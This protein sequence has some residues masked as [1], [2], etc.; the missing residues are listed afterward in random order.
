MLNDAP[1]L[2]LKKIGKSLEI[3]Y[4]KDAQR[5]NIYD[6]Q[7]NFYSPSDIY[8]ALITKDE[9][10]SAT[11]TSTKTTSTGKARNDSA[12]CRDSDNIQMLCLLKELSGL[13]SE[14]DTTGYSKR[15]KFVMMACIRSDVVKKQ[16]TSEDANINKFVE[17]NKK[18][19]D[20]AMDIASTTSG[21]ST[22]SVGAAEDEKIKIEWPTLNGGRFKRSLMERIGDV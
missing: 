8:K 11:M 7:K 3:E 20:F 19:L 14:D 17:F 15:T 9:G 18:T 22:I 10:M 21:A 12:K 2:G 5:R 1:Q 16:G 6:A 4:V 13:K